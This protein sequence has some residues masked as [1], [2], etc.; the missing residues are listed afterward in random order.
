MR[1]LQ[2]FILC[3]MFSLMAT[4]QDFIPLR[5]DS[6][7]SFFRSLDFV[8]NPIEVASFAGYSYN[9]ENELIEIRREDE[10]SSFTYPNM[11]EVELVEIFSNGSW[12]NSK[13]ITTSFDNDQPIQLLTEVY[14]N[15][16][17]VNDQLVTIDYTSDDLLKNQITQIWVNNTWANQEKVEN[18][19]DAS[20]NRILQ[21]YFNADQ[22]GDFIFT[23]GDRVQ[24][25][26]NNQPLEIIGL[27]GSDGTAFFSDKMTI[28]YN[29][30]QQQDTVVFCLYTFPDTTNCQNLS[31]S[32]FN[33]DAQE[34]RIIRNI[35][36]WNNN[37]W[38]NTGRVEEYVGRGIYSGLPD[39]IITYDYSLPTAD[40][41]ITRQYF[42]YIDLNEEE[43]RYEE[44]LFLYQFDIG[45]FVLE[46]YREEYYFKGEIVSNNDLRKI[47]QP[48][49]FPNPTSS[50]EL[51]TIKNLNFESSNIEVS[52]FDLMGKLISQEKL[53]MDFQFAGP[54]TPGIYFIKIKNENDLLLSKKLIVQ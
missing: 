20:G 28:S 33:Y 17:W 39:S 54:N 25:N 34:N 26:N 30:D 38:L 24:Y 46:K 32:I 41:R 40:Q 13:R 29:D 21:S 4:A 6:S 49:L 1:I 8:G 14:V 37:D 31:R 47:D 19:Y 7:Y 52:I 27:I 23:F 50:N 15:S 35:D 43:V 2:V 45:Q 42:N 48:I 44:S 12:E 53:E 10:R 9:T 11:Q 22:N 18:T 51:L 36:S 5:I 16:L 3:F